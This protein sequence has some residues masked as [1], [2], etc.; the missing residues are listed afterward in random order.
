MPELQKAVTALER[1]YQRPR[2]RP[3]ERPTASIPFA[4]RTMETFTG[5]SISPF[6][7]GYNVTI[8]ILAT[9]ADTPLKT[10]SHHIPI[11]DTSDETNL[12]RELTHIFSIVEKSQ[13][14]RV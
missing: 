9:E 3:T 4:P 7:D 5:I 11:G 12:L 1:S 8:A 13:A 14:G 6:E 10:V 2:F